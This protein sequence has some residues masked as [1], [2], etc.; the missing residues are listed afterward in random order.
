MMV[1]RRWRQKLGRCIFL[2]VWLIGTA[3]QSP[4]ASRALYLQVVRSSNG[5]LLWEC[6]VEPGD[7]F[8]IDYRHSSDHTPVHDLFRIDAQ[9]D[10]QAR[11]VLIEEDYL[12]YGAGLEFDPAAADISFSDGRT[13]VHLQRVLPHFLLRVGEVANHV[14]TIHQERVP[15]L[16]IAKG[17]ESVWIRTVWKETSGQ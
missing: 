3:G 10:A 13:A 9:A 11:L 14:L 2:A 16:S 6:R 17:R 7:H 1:A 8:C 4:A 15:L 5:Q 12:W